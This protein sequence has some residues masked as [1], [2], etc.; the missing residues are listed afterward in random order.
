MEFFDGDLLDAGGNRPL[1]AERVNYRRHSI[2]V[3]NVTWFL[4]R[5]CASA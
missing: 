4:D 1:V 2:A 5:S 3:N